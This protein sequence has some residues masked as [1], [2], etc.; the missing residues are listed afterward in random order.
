[1]GPGFSQ[2]LSAGSLMHYLVT[3]VMTAG[4][5]LILTDS[6]VLP[7]EFQDLLQRALLVG[8]VL[9]DFE[10]LAIQ[11]FIVIPYFR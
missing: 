5:W 7:M 8:Q 2:S 3:S 10:V 1:M 4:Q 11:G 6:H 9:V